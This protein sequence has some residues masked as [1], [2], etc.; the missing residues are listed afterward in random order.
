MDNNPYSPQGSGGVGTG[1]VG[2]TGATGPQGIQGVQGPAGGQGQGFNWRGAWASGQNYAVYDLCSN[3]GNT[4]ICS[5]AITNSTTAPPSDTG[6]F[7]IMGATGPAGPTGATGATGS[8]GAQGPTGSTGATGPQG[9]AGSTTS[10][11]SGGYYGPISFAANAVWDPVCAQVMAHS[12]ISWFWLQPWFATN[13]NHDMSICGGILKNAGKKIILRGYF[14]DDPAISGVYTSWD[15]LVAGGST[16]YNLAYLAI[17]NQIDRLGI[18]NMYAVT[19]QEEEPVIYGGTEANFITGHNAIA[20]LLRANYSGIKIIGS[21]STTV[22]DATVNA[23][24]IN[25]LL[26]YSY[27]D[28]TN[29]KALYQ[30]VI[31]RGIAIATAKGYL[32]DLYTLVDAETSVSEQYSPDTHSRNTA[33]S[34]D[35]CLS[36]N[37][38]NIG[39]YTGTP[40]YYF[41]MWNNYDY[42]AATADWANQYRHML[43]VNMLIG[44]YL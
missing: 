34:F 25:G 27:H 42:D 33:L 18:T 6:H 23:L 2:P 4:Y 43:N 21:P 26:F 8:T 29:D 15:S 1:P 32:N 16:A 7:A 31:D 39:F 40:S 13:Y 14:A 11:V 28:V 37:Y 20:A 24:D 30:A 5:V 9:P 17:K 38:K 41:M 19:I 22:A 10:L 3:G 12:K 36:D 35:L 44:K